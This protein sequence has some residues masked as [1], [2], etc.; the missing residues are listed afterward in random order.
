MNG[1]S[2]L[3]LALHFPDQY[4]DRKNEVNDIFMP[5]TA[6][7]D[8]SRSSAGVASLARLKLPLTFEA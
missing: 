2:C 7:I 8:V 5:S 4:I 6:N 3:S 1:H